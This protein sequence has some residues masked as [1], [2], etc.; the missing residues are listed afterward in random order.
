MR[1]ISA[2]IMELI[3]YIITWCIIIAIFANAISEGPAEMVGAIIIAVF[4]FGTA[5]L[6]DAT[7]TYFVARKGL[8]PKKSPTKT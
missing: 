4:F 7:L 8:H 3:G 2:A 1:H 5:H 6:G